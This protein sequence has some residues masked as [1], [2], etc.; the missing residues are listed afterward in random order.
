MTNRR[1]QR[2][3]LP[4]QPK[5]GKIQTKAG[6]IR[7]MMPEIER[8][9]EDGVTR[10]G[11]IEWLAESGIEV[12]HATFKS[13][14]QRYRARTRS[15]PTSAPSAIPALPA[16]P[17]TDRT[18]GTDPEPIT[19]GNPDRESPMPEPDTVQDESP[20]LADILDAKKSE[21]LTDQYMNRNRP[22]IGRK[23]SEKQ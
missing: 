10:Q 6:T 11:I 20:K 3:S 1:E 19:D 12:T 23:R 14:L 8:R 9:L 16:Q 5:A 22:I 21:A 2:T 15:Q 4:A 17:N 7:A 18:N 13:Y